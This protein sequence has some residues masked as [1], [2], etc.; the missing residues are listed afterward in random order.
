MSFEP[1]AKT[2]PSAVTRAS[3]TSVAVKLRS[4]DTFDSVAPFVK[5]FGRARRK[6]T[7]FGG[8]SC[9]SHLSRKKIA[10]G[11]HLRFGC[12]GQKS[13]GHARRENTSVGVHLCIVCARCKNVRSRQAQKHFGLCSFALQSPQL[14]KIEVG[15][16]LYYGRAN[17]KLTSL[18]LKLFF[19]H[20]S[21]KTFCRARRKKRF[22]RRS[23]VLRS[24]QLQKTAV[25]ELFCLGRTSH[26]NFRS[27][28]AQKFWS[29]VIFASFARVAK[30]ISSA[31]TCAPFEPVKTKLLSADTC[32]SVVPV[33]KT[34]SRAR[35]KKIGR[36]LL[37]H[38]SP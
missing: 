30:T 28:Q 14:Q 5:T 23:L 16:H 25:R 17:C 4:A 12:A 6:N 9:F 38:R 3:F 26:R 10:V 7:S 18:G 2:L 21:W 37:V 34:F 29:V 19:G 32:T 13:F 27:G 15:W 33:A 20:A 31:V 11:G 24:P 8:N 36:W 1:G 22:G 35:H